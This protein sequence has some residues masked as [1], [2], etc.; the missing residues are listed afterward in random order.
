MSAVRGLS[1][2]VGPFS[3][4]EDNSRRATETT[5]VSALGPFPGR[6]KL[7]TPSLCVK[8]HLSRNFRLGGQFDQPPSQRCRIDGPRFPLVARSED[9][10]THSRATVVVSNFQVCARRWP[11]QVDGNLIGGGAA[12]IAGHF[13]LDNQNSIDDSGGVE[14]DPRVTCTQMV[15]EPS[16][17]LF[18][19][20]EKP[21]RNLGPTLRMSEFGGIGNPY[22]PPSQRRPP[23]RESRN[24][25]SDLP[26]QAVH[27]K[28]PAAKEEAGI[29]RA[30]L[31][32]RR[33]A[34][35]F[36]SRSTQDGF[37]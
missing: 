23:L 17:I 26:V 15:L 32:A 19:R 7:M 33:E 36:R 24:K 8:P 3:Q 20:A 35:G 1:Q 10:V 13:G 18:V 28:T 37:G 30:P 29:L 5:N 9:G 25:P 4:G 31:G 6:N 14:V 27:A 12:G 2:T 34:G 16:G 21:S 22:C 11:G